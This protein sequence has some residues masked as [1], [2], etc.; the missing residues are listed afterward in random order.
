MDW[1]TG[2]VFQN[3]KL[4]AEF[5]D[6]SGRKTVADLPSLAAHGLPSSATHR[7]KVSTDFY[8]WKSVSSV[9]YLTAF[10]LPQ[11]NTASH[12]FFQFDD[13]GVEF[14]V[15]AL[16]L[17]RAFFRPAKFVLPEMFLPHGI[18]R[19]C[20]PGNQEHCEIIAEGD[21]SSRF[22]TMHRASGFLPLSWLY[23]FPS[24][25]EM[26]G[27]L[28]GNA[29]AGRVG[30]SLPKAKVQ[31]AAHGLQIGKAFYVTELRLVSLDAL[32]SPYDF[33]ETHCTTIP[34]LSAKNPCP[35]GKP[36]EPLHDAA[37]RT[38]PDGGFL[39]SDEEWKVLEPV[40][41]TNPHPRQT[42][43][44]RRLLDGIV[45]KVGTGVA[46][47]KMRCPTGTWGTASSALQRWK[48]NGVWAQVLLVLAR[49]PA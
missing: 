47:R 8:T 7:R 11:H 46:W 4:M 25:R 23:S 29:L 14:F 44:V 34:F 3:G 15:P 2:L 41:A 49:R 36:S 39:T 13:D 21:W 38:H 33:A 9:L 30:M 20:T 22:R 1:A 28:H 19:V 16:A 5:S 6:S 35:D 18:E 43:D 17:M 40:L 31:A 32:E 10:S 37:I 26:A 42:H 24:A 48:K 45:E 27:S 12:Q